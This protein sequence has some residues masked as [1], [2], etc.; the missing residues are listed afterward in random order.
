MII[1]FIANLLLYRGMSAKAAKI[2]AWAILLVAVGFILFVGKCTYDANVIEEHS[3]AVVAADVKADA[4]ATI[5]TA[6]T[7]GT[8]DAGTERAKAAADRSD[9]PLAASF[10]SLRTEAADSDKAAR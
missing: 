8:I 7:K 2:G 1:G 6:E 5:T 10:D 3:A 9:D 4:A